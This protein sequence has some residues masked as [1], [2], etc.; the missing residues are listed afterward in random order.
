MRDA[1]STTQLCFLGISPSEGD[2]SHWQAYF[3]AVLGCSQAACWMGEKD[4]APLPR[5]G[6][7]PSS[8]SISILPSL[9]CPLSLYFCP[10]P[11]IYL[12]L[13][14][15]MFPAFSLSFSSFTLCLPPFLH[16]HCLFLI[17]ANFQLSATLPLS[18]LLYISVSVSLS[19]LSSC[20]PPFPP[21][22]P[23][24]QSAAITGIGKHGWFRAQEKSGSKGTW[25]TQRG[26][27]EESR[28]VSEL[29]IRQT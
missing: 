8:I 1:L 21:L 27:S 11:H 9:P 6:L 5:I 17:F 4:L 2:R 26:L 7:L 24:L 13:L 3:P 29:S 28:K 15:I 14:F 18:V 10:L 23:H 22:S 25:D 16:C 20:S 12:F 19:G